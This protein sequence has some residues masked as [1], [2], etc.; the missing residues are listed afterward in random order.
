MQPPVLQ[1]GFTCLHYKETLESCDIVIYLVHNGTPVDGPSKVDIVQ[2]LLLKFV[3]V[4]YPGFCHSNCN[5]Y[6]CVTNK[7]IFLTLFLM[8][9]Q[10][11]ATAICRVN[12]PTNSSV[13]HH[14]KVKTLQSVVVVRCHWCHCKKQIGY[15][16]H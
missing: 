2:Y 9:L 13:L 4:V 15:F 5:F 6:F 11:F 7:N 16:N 1:E 12:C 10:R 14:C 3:T 8:L